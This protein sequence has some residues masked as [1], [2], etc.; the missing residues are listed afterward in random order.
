MEERLAAEFSRFDVVAQTI[1]R[2]VEHLNTWQ[3]DGE[4]LTQQERDEIAEFVGQELGLSDP[5]D[6]VEMTKS[7]SNNAYMQ[8]V[9]QV[10]QL[11]QNVKR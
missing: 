10:S 6:F 8:L 5:G 3:R 7:A 9:T 11:I 1:I 4:P 2:I